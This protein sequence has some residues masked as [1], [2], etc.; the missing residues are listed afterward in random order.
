MWLLQKINSSQFFTIEHMV[1][2][3]MCELVNQYPGGVYVHWSFWHN[4]EPGMAEPTA[5]LLVE[6]KATE[7]ARAQCQAF[8]LAIFRIDTP[9]ALAR[10]GGKQP[11]NRRRDTDLDIRLERARAEPAPAAAAPPPVK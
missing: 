9:E 5:K 1:R 4:A 11:V 8:K 6:T 2:K 7:V 10:F 3:Q